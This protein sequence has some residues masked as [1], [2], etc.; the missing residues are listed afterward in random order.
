[1]FVCCCLLLG[2][3]GCRFVVEWFCG[4]GMSTCGMPRRVVLFDGL[5]VVSCGLGWLFVCVAGVVCGCVCLSC[6]VWG[7]WFILLFA[8]SI[9]FGGYFLFDLLVIMLV[10]VWLVLVFGVVLL[11]TTCIFCVAYCCLWCG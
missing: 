2:G 6:L 4:L 5:L 11:L 10:I 9:D 1:M 8:C 3:F 7:L